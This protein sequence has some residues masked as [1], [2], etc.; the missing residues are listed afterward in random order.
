MAYSLDALGEH[1]PRGARSRP[2]CSP[3]RRQA[4][5]SGAGVHRVGVASRSQNPTRAGRGEGAAR[6]RSR[7]RSPARA[8]CRSPRRRA[9]WRR[10]A[11][12]RGSGPA[13]CPMVV[14][15]ED[16]DVGECA[17]HEPAPVPQAVEAGRD[18]GQ[19]AHGLLPAEEPAGADAVAQHGRGV[20]GAAHGVEVG[21]GV[22]PADD[23][24][25][26]EP[27]L[28][29]GAPSPRRTR[30]WAGAGRC[31]GGPPP[32]RRG[33]RRTARRRDARATSPTAD[34]SSVGV[35]RGERL[36]QDETVPHG[37]VPEDA[38]PRRT[39][40]RRRAGAACR[41]PTSA[42]MRSSIGR[43]KT[44]RQPGRPSRMAPCS[45]LSRNCMVWGRVSATTVA[46]RSA[47]AEPAASWLHAPSGFMAETPSTFQLTGR[48]ASSDMVARKSTSSSVKPLRQPATMSS[49]VVPSWSRTAAARRSISA[50]LAAREGTGCPSPSLCVWTWE[51]EKP[52]APS[53][54]RGVQRRHHGVEVRRRGVAAHRALAHHQPAQSR[55]PDQEAGVDRDP[56]VEPVQPLPEGR[57]VP[58]QPGPQRGERHPLRPGPSSARCSR[59]RPGPAEPA[60]TRSCRRGP[61]SPRAAATG[62][63]R[64]PRRAGRRSG[65]GGRRSPVRPACPGRR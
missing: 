5:V 6:G 42:A 7:S 48:S 41:G 61:W 40:R 47:A 50:R 62:W 17:G 19:L 53:A 57:P 15:V 25:R 30:R 34:P 38:R 14:G 33:G 29:P 43:A 3:D 54:K 24:P 10:R 22:G 35:L 63:R 23:G 45:K 9:G 60:R 28:Q 11:G 51:V 31:A 2:A 65:C 59:P 4:G 16:D 39:A 36:L 12:R 49:T 1:D 13:S 46:P 21:P 64:G 8:R 27:R 55:V 44:S 58:G 18:V 32:R 37:E 52:S 26:V 20:D 56:P